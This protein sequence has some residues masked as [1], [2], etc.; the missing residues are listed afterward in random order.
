MRFSIVCKIE[1]KDSHELE[2]FSHLLARDIF[3]PHQRCL[4]DDF[5]KMEAD[6]SHRIKREYVH[7]YFFALTQRKGG[8][9]VKP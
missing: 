7:A 3:L 5:G 8:W 1:S 9:I 2:S 4:V 6:S